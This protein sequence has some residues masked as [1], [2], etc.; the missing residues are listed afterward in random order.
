MYEDL[1]ECSYFISGNLYRN[2]EDEIK[3]RR[4]CHNCYFCRNISMGNRIND[5]C[6]KW[7]H[8]N[9]E[10]IASKDFNAYLLR[11]VIWQNL[12]DEAL[13]DFNRE[14]DSNGDLIIPGTGKM[15][16]EEYNETINYMNRI[17]KMIRDG[18]NA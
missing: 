17:G 6:N 3:E 14:H 1:Y 18:K 16:E 10:A 8:L 12:G 13:D 5:N 15:K 2:K 9:E 7:V 4:I 11:H